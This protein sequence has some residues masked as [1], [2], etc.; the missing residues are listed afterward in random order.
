MSKSKLLLNSSLDVCVVNHGSRIPGQEAALSHPIADLRIVPSSACVH[1]VQALVYTN[2]EILESFDIRF[3][4]QEV[5]SDCLSTLQ[6]VP[7]QREQERVYLLA[8]LFFHEIWEIVHCSIRRIGSRSFPRFQGFFSFAVW[9][10]KHFV[11]SLFLHLGLTW[12]LSELCRLD[13][14][15][16]WE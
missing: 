6:I 16:P 14:S 4:W 2:R 13:C 8:V 9:I 3:R 10:L 15:S 11:Q 7:L 12:Y 5:T 1:S